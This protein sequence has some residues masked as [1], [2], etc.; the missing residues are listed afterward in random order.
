[1]LLYSLTQLLWGSSINSNPL[2]TFLSLFYLPR[3]FAWTSPQQ[4]FNFSLPETSVCVAKDSRLVSQS[5]AQA[6]FLL[7]PF[8]FD[9]RAME[10]FYPQSTHISWRVDTRKKTVLIPSL[11][12]ENQNIYYLCKLSAPNGTRS[13]PPC[14]LLCNAFQWWRTLA[15]LPN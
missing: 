4:L 9:S 5:W 15:T 1:M 10:S 12:E 2:P 7:Q 13:V 11:L 14:S 8:V 3:N 6:I